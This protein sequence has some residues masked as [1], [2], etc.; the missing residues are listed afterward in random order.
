MGAVIDQRAYDKHAGAL[1]RARDDAT[2]T[3]AAGGT[4]D[5]SEGYFVRPTVLVGTDPENEIFTTEYF[6][7]ILSVHVFDDGDYDTVMRS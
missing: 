3:V 1:E 5:D 6:G 7:P 2:I 4:C